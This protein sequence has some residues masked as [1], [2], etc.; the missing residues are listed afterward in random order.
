MP[1]ARHCFRTPKRAEYVTAL[2]RKYAEKVSIFY[3]ERVPLFQLLKSPG[4]VEEHAIE[5]RILRVVSVE[6]RFLQIVEDV[7]LTG[8]RNV[9]DG[10]HHDGR[11][12]VVFVARAIPIEGG[13]DCG[14]RQSHFFKIEKRGARIA[15]EIH[16]LLLGIYAVNE[17]EVVGMLFIELFSAERQIKRVLSDNQRKL[18]TDTGG[19]ALPQIVGTQTSGARARQ[20]TKFSVGENLMLGI[21]NV[22]SKLIRLD[23]YNVIAN[24]IFRGNAKK[25]VRREQVMIKF[26]S[27]PASVILTNVF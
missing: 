13:F 26:I 22:F 25:A 3:R 17:H 9:V 24:D 12:R 18:R 8:K 2:R 23:V 11:H 10:F 4:S 6:E 27:E 14:E 19:N 1:R 16:N 15:A 21:D 7:R 5:R 20:R